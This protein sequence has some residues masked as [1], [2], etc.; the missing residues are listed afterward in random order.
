MG[1][2]PCIVHCL[3]R[4]VLLG[5]GISEWRRTLFGRGH[6]REAILPLHGSDRR[7]DFCS[8]SRTNT[9]G[10]VE[11]Q[12]APT[13]PTAHDSSPNRKRFRSHTAPSHRGA[14]TS[15]GLR[16]RLPILRGAFHD[17]ARGEVV[18]H[19]PQRGDDLRHR[20]RRRGLELRRSGGLPSRSPDDRADSR[21]DFRSD[22]RSDSCSDSLSHSRSDSSSNI[23]TY[24]FLGLLC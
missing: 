14:P 3:Q 21:S 15:P 5:G 24:R 7:S 16:V 2:Q 19:L 1:R 6:R 18:Y 4:R 20:G 9:R 17:H 23:G 22:L 13:S 10:D 11:S 12:L 8:D